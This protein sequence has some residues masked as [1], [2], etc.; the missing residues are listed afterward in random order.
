M[1]SPMFPDIPPDP[2]VMSNCYVCLASATDSKNIILDVE[3][4]EIV[5]PKGHPKPHY[6][7]A[8][9]TS[10]VAPYCF[11]KSGK[12]ANFTLKKYP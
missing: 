5:V 1:L 2:S 3:N 10:K 11:L 6:V 7:L 4:R 8:K 12:K 9:A